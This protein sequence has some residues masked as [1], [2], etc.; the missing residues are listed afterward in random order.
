MLCIAGTAP[1][2][3]RAELVR[4]I[5]DP[6]IPLQRRMLNAIKG[7]TATRHGEAAG[8]R[9]CN[10]LPDMQPLG[11]LVVA[12]SYDKDGTKTQVSRQCRSIRSSRSY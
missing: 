6:A 1:F 9:W 12:R 10:R 4:L 7:L 11:K 5:S 3:E 8:L 2:Y